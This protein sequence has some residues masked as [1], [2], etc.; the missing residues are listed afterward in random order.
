MR[1]ALDTNRYVDLGRGSAEV[2]KLVERADSV[3]LPFV[4]VAELRSG[5]AVGTR[6]IANERVVRRF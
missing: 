4:V 6:S 5:F 2:V 1:L 3:F